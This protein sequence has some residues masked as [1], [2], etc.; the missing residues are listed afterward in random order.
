MLSC[1]RVKGVSLLRWR[2]VYMDKVGRIL[3]VLMIACAVW[4]LLHSDWM[5]F[6]MFTAWGL[7]EL[8]GLNGPRELQGIRKT[9][10][11]ITFAMAVIRLIT[12]IF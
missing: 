1:P 7:S 10:M 6:V 3:G 12:I 2:E 5:L 8:I 4:Y 9:L 11:W